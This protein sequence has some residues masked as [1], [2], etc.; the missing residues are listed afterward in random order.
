M[1]SGSA[2]GSAYSDSEPLGWGYY[3]P[4]Y[5][6]VPWVTY[7]KKVTE[8]TKAARRKR[9]ILAAEGRLGSLSPVPF[10]VDTNLPITIERSGLSGKT[11]R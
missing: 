9:S 1:V 7:G 3:A 10:E 11:G 2:S 4:E 5:A 6:H 8:T